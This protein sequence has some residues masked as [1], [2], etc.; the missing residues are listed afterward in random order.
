M[1]S[2]EN[3]VFDPEKV[4][5]TIGECNF[6]EGW[7]DYDVV[8]AENYDKLLALYRLAKEALES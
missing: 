6:G 8:E 5:R 3:E 1:E 2:M 4:K 7:Y